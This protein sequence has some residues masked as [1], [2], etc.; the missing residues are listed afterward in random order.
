MIPSEYGSAAP[1]SAKSPR[2]RYEIDEPPALVDL[3]P[4]E[5]TRQQLQLRELDALV[6]A[7]EDLVHVGARLDELGR[8]AQRLRGRVR[9]LEPPGVGDERDVERLRDLRGQLDVQLARA[10]RARSR[11]STTRPRRRR[12]TPPNRVLSWWWSTLTTSG[13]LCSTSG[14]GPSRLSF[15]QS[16]ASSTRSAQSSGSVRAQVV[17]R[18]E[19]VLAGQRRLPAGT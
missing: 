5:R 2:R 19:R 15:A 9:V 10:G 1:T 12:F 7:L 11:R 17:E 13:A 4:L 8:E 16:S 14:S 3:R 18:H 6:D